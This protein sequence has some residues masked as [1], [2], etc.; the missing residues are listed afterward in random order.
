ML[1][2]H[3]AHTIQMYDQLAEVYASKWYNSSVLDPLID[4]FCNMLPQGA[5]ILDAGCGCG[6]DVRLLRE[7]KFDVVGVD[8]SSGL[9]H[10]ARFR[11]PGAYFRLM[12]IR[13]LKYPNNLFDGI[14]CAAVINHLVEEDLFAALQNFVRVLKPGGIA[15]ITF[16][17]GDG[18]EYDHFR[19]FYYFY[20]KEK[21]AKIF[22]DFGF[23]IV[24]QY[25]SGDVSKVVWNQFIFKLKKQEE[26]H[27]RN[28]FFCYKNLFPQ[29]RTSGRTIA[30]SI[31]YGDSNLF[32]AVD[33][34][35]LIEGHLL[36]ITNQHFS[37]M[38]RADVKIEKI[39]NVK[40]TIRSMT[41]G[42][43]RRSTLFLEHGTTEDKAKETSCID[44][45]HIHS[46]PLR[47][48]I[49]SRIE[50]ALG[51]MSR[52]SS[53]SQL[54]RFLASRE[55]IYYEAKSGEG[56][57]RYDDIDQIQ[58]QFFRVVAGEYLGRSNVKWAAV[59]KDADTEERFEKTITMFSKYLDEE[60]KLVPI[61][62]RAT[63][64]RQNTLRLTR[65]GLRIRNVVSISR[66]REK[67][68]PEETLGELGE[69]RITNEIIR[70][71][72]RDKSRYEQF[73]GDDVARIDPDL[74]EDEVL[75]ATVDPCPRPIAFDLGKIDYRYFGWLCMVISLSDLSA[76]AASPV[77][78]LLSCEMPPN[79]R[80]HDF[81]DFLEGVVSIA[82]KYECPII[83]GNIKDAN[84]FS[85]TN[86]MLGKAKVDRLFRRSGAVPGDAIFMIGS[87]G[88]FWSAILKER[89]N[90]LLDR[91]QEVQLDRALLYPEPNLFAAIELS[92][93]GV[94]SA[95]M[96]ASD[97]PTGCFS[98]LASTNNLDVIIQRDALV[99]DLAVRNVAFQLGIDPKILMLTWGNWEIVFTANR[100]KLVDRIGDSPLIDEVHWIGDCVRGAGRVYYD[101]ISDETEVPD[102]VSSRF[103][104]RSSFSHGIEA[105]EEYLLEI[106][107]V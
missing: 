80:V 24:H 25:I 14:I 87:S 89:H 82:S 104:T 38:M 7:R 40:H 17:T 96:D 22:R 11:L 29:N 81:L 55:Y 103:S 95:C 76:S 8:L 12:D 9:L 54:R 98:A 59:L 70:Q 77:G 30:G 66:L 94:V 79:M 4:N 58:S 26:L 85:C 18:T 62:S 91:D 16:K 20:S 42:A 71:A 37:S 47:Y 44:H 78:T 106:A 52:S 2:D 84:Q 88:L 32:V 53:K 27:D 97:G 31:L 15:C 75:V 73:I 3:L 49:K 33:C 5:V 100:D 72:F 63:E 1:F 107:K 92:K 90:L 19:R 35:P 56:Y 36:A 101:K 48:N 39:N 23:E 50:E 65:S 51:P 34:S 21:I 74:Q 93:L 67:Y 68:G 43:M 60:Q 69:S 10:E 102:I 86:T 13:Q 28:C 99:P 6:R 46:L 45:A 83:G 105:Y 41:D 57:F 61:Y 64:V